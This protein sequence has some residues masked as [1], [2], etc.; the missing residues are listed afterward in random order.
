MKGRDTLLV[1]EMGVKEDEYYPMFGFLFVLVAAL[2]VSGNITTLIL[3]KK[4]DTFRDTSNGRLF[5]GNLAVVDLLNSILALFSGLGYINKDIIMDSNVKLC[6]LTAYSRWS[7]PYLAVFALTLLSINRYCITLHHN[8]AGRFFERK[9]SWMY[10]LSSWLVLFLPF[11]VLPFLDTNTTPTF[12]NDRGL[13]RVTLAPF[14][15]VNFYL[16]F[17]CLLS[18]FYFNTRIYF[19]IKRHNRS[20]RDKNIINRFEYVER[21]KKVAK[22]V[23]AMFISYVISY[24]PVIVR[25]IYLP[26]T[27]N[28]GSLLSPLAFLFNN[29]NYINN[30]FIYGFMDKTYRRKLKKLFCK[31]SV[32]HE[33]TRVGT[34]LQRNIKVC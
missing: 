29:I 12:Q 23:L 25:G 10:V 19:R 14:F 11:L 33:I 24:V 26:T 6:Y 34:S 4:N 2:G 8:R 5:L 21:N 18:M 1:P 28:A 9:M 13:C 7:L 16:S 22:I 27:G 17:L 32:Q 31:N 20:V 30:V 15:S 3:I